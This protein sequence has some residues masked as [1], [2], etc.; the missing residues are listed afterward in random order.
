MPLCGVKENIS[1]VSVLFDLEL[2]DYVPLTNCS[3][4]G[5]ADAQRWKHVYQCH[6][7]YLQERHDFA[8]FCFRCDDWFIAESAWEQHCESHLHSP[9][10]MV[11]CDPLIYGGTLVEPGCCPV[12]QSNLKNAP[13]K[14]MYQFLHRVPW[15]QHIIRCLGAWIK[16]HSN[17]EGK[18]A[19]LPCPHP[20]PKCAEL[21]LSVLELQFHLEDIHCI[22][23]IKDGRSLLIINATGD[24]GT[25]RRSQDSLLK[26]SKSPQTARSGGKRKVEV[27]GAVA[28]DSVL[29][30]DVD[31]SPR[32]SKRRRT[33]PP[34]RYIGT[35]SYSRSLTRGTKQESSVSLALEVAES[36]KDGDQSYID[37]C[38]DPHLHRIGSQEF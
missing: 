32:F 22:N 37:D 34:T 38:I 1:S 28:Q 25:K 26:P 20:H 6:K 17:S 29:T 4:R 10:C 18:D 33:A 3:Y 35:R 36:E 13:S 8:E 16:Q 31:T 23:T 21:S 24:Y 11:Q 15:K 30:A 7:A 19:L 12:C 2:N 5:E 9:N 27:Q 14:R